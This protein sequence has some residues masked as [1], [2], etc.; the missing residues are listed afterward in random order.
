MFYKYFF[1]QYFQSFK[2]FDLLL[3]FFMRSNLGGFVFF[4]PWAFSES[5][6]EEAI[7]AVGVLESEPRSLRL[8]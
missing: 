3:L 7:N 1:G 4:L 5:L 6:A 2:R 8:L